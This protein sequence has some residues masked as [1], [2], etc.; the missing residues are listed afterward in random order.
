MMRKM[1]PYVIVRFGASLLTGE[2]VRKNM[3]CIFYGNTD[4]SIVNTLFDLQKVKWNRRL[5]SCLNGYYCCSKIWNAIR[6][7]HKRSRMNGAVVNHNPMLTY[8]LRA[9]P[10]W[11]RPCSNLHANG[12]GS[13][14]SDFQCSSKNQIAKDNSV[15]Q[16]GN[17]LR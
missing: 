16:M 17:T 10:H 13:D 2:L 7:V 8:L 14:S 6:A 5:R 4:M 1:G 9:T 3:R 11:Q 12:R 15:H